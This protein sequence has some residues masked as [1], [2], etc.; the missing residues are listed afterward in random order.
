MLSNTQSP[1]SYSSNSVA[2]PSYTVTPR[3]VATSYQAPNYEDKLSGS[4]SANSVPFNVSD[5]SETVDYT[6]EDLDDSDVN[7]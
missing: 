1:N 5:S 3:P 7:F 2:V 4:D 6:D